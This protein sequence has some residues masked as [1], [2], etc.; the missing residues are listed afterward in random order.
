MENPFYFRQQIPFFYDKT[1]KEFKEDSYERYDPMVIRQSAL[2]LE[3]ELW[4]GYPMK[5]ILQYSN[6]FIAD[7]NPTS[8]VEIGCGV[9][10]WIAD[11]AKEFPNSDCWGIDYSYQMLKRANEVW[12][13]KG[14]IEI[15]L[16]SFG[17]SSEHKLKTNRLS[18]LQFGLAKANQ[19]PFQ[20][21]SK[22]LV[23]SSFLLDRLDQPIEG[24]QEMKRIL[25]P[26][27][28]LIL[29]T[30]LNFKQA[31]HWEQFFP[32]TKIHTLLKNIGFKIIDSKEN[33]LI[34]EPLDIRGNNIQWNCVGFICERI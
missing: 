14:S 9:G 4:N 20:K 6:P 2:H 19:L 16:S 29:I 22:D 27:G 13:R 25:K 32:A 12:I 10:R 7:I 24:L 21:E 5:P 3:D 18:N 15:D 23:L 33:I 11:L 8:I 31:K 17:F 28:Q 30:P 34:K 1:E 26:N